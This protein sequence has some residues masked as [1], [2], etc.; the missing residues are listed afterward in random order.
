METGTIYFA[1]ARPKDV[2]VLIVTGYVSSVVDITGGFAYLGG[3]SVLR[4]FASQIRL[5]GSV[6]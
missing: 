2:G 1:L 6:A 5:A 3:V 4:Q